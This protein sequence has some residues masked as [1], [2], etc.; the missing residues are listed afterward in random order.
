[1][2]N[3]KKIINNLY[4]GDY[5]S[6]PN[7]CEFVLSVA[8]E[9][10][11]QKTANLKLK[12]NDI[13]FSFDNQK[14]FLNLLDYPEIGNIDEDTLK[15]GLKFIDDCLKK[16]KNL[17][18]HCIWGVNRSPSIVFIYLVIT[19]NLKYNNFAD[20][21][22]QFKKI[23]WKSNPNPAYWHYLNNQFPYNDLNWNNTIE[24]K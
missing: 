24:E 12:N 13:Y 18:V 9:L 3:Y 2:K 19:K 14:L 8:S 20:A 11:L 21:W 1:M 15:I 7:S 17:Y 23:Y 16:N 10:F 4:L 5:S 22:K 6:I